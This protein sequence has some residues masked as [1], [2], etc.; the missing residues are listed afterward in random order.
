MNKKT[1]RVPLV[2]LSTQAECEV[3]IEELNRL[4]EHRPVT[5]GDLNDV[6]GEPNFYTD[7][8]WGWCD[9]SVV[10]IKQV[11]GGWQ[12]IFPDPKRV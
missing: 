12:I 10:G 4:F 8:Q 9:N 6:L 1:V 7:H 2:I 5:L 11:E 3:V